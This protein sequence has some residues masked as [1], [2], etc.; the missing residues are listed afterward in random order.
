M[1]SN[2]TYAAIL[3]FSDK[4]TIDI[5][6][7]AFDGATCA[8]KDENYIEAAQ[9]WL[10]SAIMDAEDAG[11]EIPADISPEKIALSKKQKLVYVNVWMPY[12][13]S[14]V[15][16]T[17]VKK[18]LTIPAWLDVLAKQNSVNFSETLVQALK[19]KLGLEK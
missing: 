13:R 10:A 8:E 5:T 4:D 19:T 7:P 9:D 18:T 11:E 14:K 6:F 12:H 1:D 16:E 2:Y 17:Y 15:K 3:D